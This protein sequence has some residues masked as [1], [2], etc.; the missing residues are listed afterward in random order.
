MSRL[1]AL[2]SSGFRA[3]LPSTSVLIKPSCFLIPA[4]GV[5]FALGIQAGEFIGHGLD[6]PILRKAFEQL[7]AGGGVGDQMSGG[8]VGQGA[9]LIGQPA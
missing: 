2:R 1:M 4:L 5:Q 9:R 3:L 7:A 8:G 6:T